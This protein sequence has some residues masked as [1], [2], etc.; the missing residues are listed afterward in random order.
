MKHILHMA[1]FCSGL[2]TLCQA[3]M[4][5]FDILLETHWKNLTHNNKNKHFNDKLILAANI[6]FKKKS[7]DV[8]FL[9]ELSLTWQ[10]KKLNKLIGSLYEKD[11]L[12]N[13]MPIEKFHICDGI[14]KTSEQKLI[15]K[16]EKPK[17]LSSEN[18]LC[19]VLI[20]PQNIEKKL[21]DGIFH[22]EPTNLPKQYRELVDN[23]NL[24]LAIA[25]NNDL[26]AHIRN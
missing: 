20:V 8:V 5:Q 9:Q 24:T 2:A 26:N 14:W 6:T 22:L 11:I 25:H 19:L 17:K 4:A 16:F 18:T 1:V 10:G 21:K 12:G 13:F 7:S 15:L 23:N 3:K